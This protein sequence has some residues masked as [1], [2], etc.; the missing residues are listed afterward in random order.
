MTVAF[1]DE[2]VEVGGVD[3]VEGL[4]AQVV[5][6]RTQ[7]AHLPP[8]VV[9]APTELVARSRAVDHAPWMAYTLLARGSQRL[10]P[11]LLPP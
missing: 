10:P 9:P 5:T 7:S 11:W 6:P 3:S 8:T 4:E 2:L 1:D